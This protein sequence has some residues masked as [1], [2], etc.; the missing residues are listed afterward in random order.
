MVATGLNAVN[1]SSRARTARESHR[2]IKTPYFQLPEEG[3]TTVANGAD[4][5][6]ESSDPR[7][8]L[9]KER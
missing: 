4:P 5:R 7:C 8:V 1:L 6:E 9:S 3:P 2:A